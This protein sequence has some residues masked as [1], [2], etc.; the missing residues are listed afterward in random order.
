MIRLRLKRRYFADT[1]TIGD[2]YIK[3]D[4]E[5]EYFFSNTLEDTVRELKTIE[6]KI[7]CETAIPYGTYKVILNISPKFKRLLPR[8]LNVPFFEGILIHRGNKANDSCGC[9]LIGE[10]K[11]KGMVINSTKYENGLVNLIKDDDDIKI[12]IQ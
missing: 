4:Y 11:I 10:N 5:E 7:P 1:Y 6:D 2:L 12:I 9:I 3:K 8:L